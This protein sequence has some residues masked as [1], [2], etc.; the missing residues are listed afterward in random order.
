MENACM[1]NMSINKVFLVSS[2]TACVKDIACLGTS[3]LKNMLHLQNAAWQTLVN[4]EP[5]NQRY[6]FAGL[7]SLQNVVLSLALFSRV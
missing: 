1:A 2:I 7:G 6:V 3:S 4:Q 5:H